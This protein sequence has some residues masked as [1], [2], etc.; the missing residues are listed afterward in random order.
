MIIYEQAVCPLRC[1]IILTIA[2]KQGELEWIIVVASRFLKAS[3]V[4]SLE[5]FRPLR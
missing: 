2:V 5:R 3:A 4:A 1:L